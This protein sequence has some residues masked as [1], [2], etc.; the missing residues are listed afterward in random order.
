MWLWLS[1]VVVVSTARYGDVLVDVLLC[2]RLC[3]AVC[4]CFEVLIVYS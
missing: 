4:G 2:V 3:M 1:L